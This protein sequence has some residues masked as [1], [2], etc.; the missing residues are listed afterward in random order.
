MS[1]VMNILLGIAALI[2]LLMVGGFVVWTFHKGWSPW[3][4]DRLTPVE[5]IRADV[6][7]KEEQ[8][9]YSLH[10]QKVITVAWR[11]AFRCEDSKI[12]IYEVNKDVFDTLEEND[13][14]MLLYKG[15][16]FVRFEPT[17]IG[18]DADELYRRVV[19]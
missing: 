12:R 9:E 15:N 10:Y 13:H 18:V 16:T 7:V 14:G 5:R 11:I 3:V 1:V 19:R 17:R 6:A 8:N 2:Y 4:R